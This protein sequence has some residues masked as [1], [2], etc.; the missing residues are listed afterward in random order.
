MPEDPCQAEYEA[1]LIAQVATLICQANELIAEA[2][3]MVCQM[4][5]MDMAATESLLDGQRLAADDRAFRRTA[6][7]HVKMSVREIPHIANRKNVKRL[8]KRLEQ[9]H[10]LLKCVKAMQI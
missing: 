7:E 1:L 8:S 5:H 9:S 10:A 6:C 4:E 2:D 3:L